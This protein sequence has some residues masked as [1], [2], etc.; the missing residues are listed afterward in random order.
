M[1]YSTSLKFHFPMS[2]ALASTFILSLPTILFLLPL[3]FGPMRAKRT[4]TARLPLFFILLFAL[5]WIIRLPSAPYLCPFIFCSSL[6]SVFVFIEQRF[7]C[8]IFVNASLAGLHFAYISAGSLV[9][10]TWPRWFRSRIVCHLFL[11]PACLILFFLL[12]G[13]ASGHCSFLG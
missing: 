9:L 12:F 13:L 1:C 4:F 11:Y 3:H 6:G 8:L 10:L 2:S 7:H 5:P